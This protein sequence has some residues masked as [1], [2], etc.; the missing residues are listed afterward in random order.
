[1]KAIIENGWIICPNCKKKQF[2]LTKNAEIHGQEWK[3]KG[4]KNLFTVNTPY[5]CEEGAVLVYP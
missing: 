1:M 2:P 4:C 3:C 5:H